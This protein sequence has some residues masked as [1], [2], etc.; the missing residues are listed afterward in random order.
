MKKII[1]ILIVD[2]EKD[3]RES[4]GDILIDEGFNVFLAKNASVAIKY[5]K[6]Q[7]IDL[8][9]LDIWMPDIDGISLLKSWAKNKEINCPVLM[10]SGHGTIDT[11]IEATK[12]GATDFLEKPISL[13][14]LL[15]SISGALKK[16]VEIDKIDKYFLEN[17]SLKY[18]ND[19]KTDLQAL[20]NSYFT[21]L[22]GPKGNFINVCKSI[23]VSSSSFQIDSQDL[24][25]TN[26]IKAVSYT[27]LTLPT[28]Y[29]V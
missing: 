1:N 21:A 6:K 4:L 26:I 14:K 18:V 13:Q 5:K 3:I 11:A 27:H 24:I 20:K 22:V 29:S 10:M 15:K 23:L 17:N 28:I 25:T 16:S 12:I 2:D 8:I 7:K 9:L 19:F